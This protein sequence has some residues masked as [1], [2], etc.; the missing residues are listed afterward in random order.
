MLLLQTSRFATHVNHRQC[1]DYTSE[2][3]LQAFITEAMQGGLGATAAGGD[4]DMERILRAVRVS[5][6]SCD[7][8]LVEEQVANFG[9][10]RAR[11]GNVFG[12]S[13]NRKDIV[14]YTSSPPAGRQGRVRRLADIGAGGNHRDELEDLISRCTSTRPTARV[15]MVVEMKAKRTGADELQAPHRITQSLPPHTRPAMKSTPTPES[16]MN[17]SCLR[18]QSQL[19]RYAYQMREQDLLVVPLVI[20]FLM[21]PNPPHPLGL[22]MHAWWLGH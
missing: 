4:T 3:S 20:G 13:K 15:L 18:V 10:R 21:V 22:S 12:N 14:M 19:M 9:G 7:I 1:N 8:T 6:A 11:G 16:K 17:S 2:R 5:L